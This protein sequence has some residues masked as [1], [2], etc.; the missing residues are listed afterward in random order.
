MVSKQINKIFAVRASDRVRLKELS[1][2]KLGA[3]WPVLIGNQS[4]T[5]EIK[6]NILNLQTLNA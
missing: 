2:P 1:Q 3:H 6:N 5:P 4:M